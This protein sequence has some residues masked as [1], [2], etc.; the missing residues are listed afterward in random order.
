MIVHIA[1]FRWR[2][3]ISQ[4]QINGLMRSISNLK[5]KIPDVVSLYAGENFSKWNEGYTHAVVVTTRTRSG[6]DSYRNHPAHIPVAKAVD[7]MEEQSI[8]IDFEDK[9]CG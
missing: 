1:L 9:S 3:N 5:N 2:E 6:L 7:K 8:G 4:E